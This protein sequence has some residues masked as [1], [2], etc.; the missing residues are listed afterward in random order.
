[1]K[2]L[3]LVDDNADQVELMALAIGRLGLRCSVVAFDSGAACLAALERGVVA[4]GLIVIDVAMPGM[5]GP[6]TVRCIRLLAGGRQ[7]PI[8]VLSTSDLPC[9]R[10]RSQAAGADAYVLKPLLDRTWVET[11]QDVMTH[12]NGG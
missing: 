11:V 8:V 1:M 3:V 6:A 7:V 12:W 5:D 10:Q 4:P 2:P 9:D